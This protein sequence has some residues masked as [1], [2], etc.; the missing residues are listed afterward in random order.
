MDLA[1]DSQRKTI[2]QTHP[3]IETTRA[4]VRHDQQAQRYESRKKMLQR[5]PERSTR[6]DSQIET[7]NVRVGHVRLLT[8]LVKSRGR[9]E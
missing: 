2:V 5:R 8:R 7:K 1:R 6:N 4:V 9:V 3:E